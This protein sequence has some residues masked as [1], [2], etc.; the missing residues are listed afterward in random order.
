VSTAH[1]RPEAF[2]PLRPLELLVLAMLADAP[3]HGYAVRQ[4]ILDHTGDAIEV[5]AGNLYRHIRRLH[6]ESLIDVTQRSSRAPDDERR[7]YFRLTALGR[8]VLS[9]ELER[10]R[11]LVRFAEQRQLIGPART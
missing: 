3:L 2:L 1:D 8:R 6:A 10:L 11:A 7:R 9:A 4:A 5:E